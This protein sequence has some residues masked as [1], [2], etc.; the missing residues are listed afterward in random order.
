MN[1]LDWILSL[2]ISNFLYGLFISC[3]LS[4]IESKLDSLMRK[5]EDAHPTHKYEGEYDYLD[6]LFDK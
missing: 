3:N 2:C 6:G 5:M 1:A 4:T